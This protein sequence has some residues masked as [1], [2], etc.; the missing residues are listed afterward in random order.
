MCNWPD[1]N[2]EEMDST[3]AVQQV[4]FKIIFD[5]VLFC[6]FN[7]SNSV[8]LYLLKTL[9]IVLVYITDVRFD[10]IIEER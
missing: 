3:L 8:I 4:G 2:F 7:F 5:F 1:E 10:S 9:I 6:C